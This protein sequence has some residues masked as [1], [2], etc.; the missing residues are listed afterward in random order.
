VNQETHTQSASTR[1]SVPAESKK[2][3]EKGGTGVTWGITIISSVSLFLTLLGY[4]VSL[5]VETRFG[6]PHQTVYSSV[7]DLV[8]LSVYAVLSLVLRLGEVSWLPLFEQA[9]LPALL[10][11][12]G[13]FL[14]VCC[15][16]FLRVRQARSRA[17]TNR[18]W[19]YFGTPTEHDSTGQLLGKGAIG[20]GMFGGLVFI[21]PFLIAGALLV[22]MV[23]I[24]V[25]P[26]FGMQ[27]GEHYF[28]K[29]VVTPTTCEPVTS[30][31][32]RLKAWSTPQKEKA[33]AATANCVALY[34]DETQVASGRVVV[35]TSSAIVLFDPTSGAVRRVPIG[36]LTVQP[37]GA[38]QV[39]V[40]GIIAK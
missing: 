34:K 6:M 28:R 30:Q 12:T 37:I 18:F 1:T 3:E 7:L 25:V 31:A 24:S 23:L 14:L 40:I 22:S 2:T 10:A 17:G 19:R 8:G 33:A 32:M 35:S 36:E 39:G 27:L 20:S 21:T 26:M 13:M 38:I 9:W 16:V 15:M 5:A 4:G 11:A 29:F